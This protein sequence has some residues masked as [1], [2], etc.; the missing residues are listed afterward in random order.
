[1][2]D[3]IIVG[4][5]V[6][7]CASAYQLARRGQKVL[8]I[9]QFAL[10]HERG[11]SHGH[12]RIIRRS[13]ETPG[14]VR[15]MDAAY[16]AWR[17]LEADADQRLIVT[18]G[19]LDLGHPERSDVLSC[20]ESMRAE[21]VPFELMDAATVRQRFS[22]FVVSDSYVGVYQ[23]DAGILPASQCVAVLAQQAVSYGA[24][25]VAGQAV[26]R[27]APDGAGVIVSAGANTYRAQRAIITAGS[28]VS[29]LLTQ[30]D[31]DL[32]LEITREQVMFFRPQQP[33]AFA[34]GKFPIFIQYG[35]RSA[36]NSTPSFYGF[37]LFGEDGVKV[38]EHH[39]GRVIDPFTDDGAVDQ[40]A[41]KRAHAFLGD[42]I[43]LAAGELMLAQTCRYTNTPDTHFIVDRHPHYP[44]IVIGSPCSGHGFKFGA[45][46][47]SILADLAIQGETIHDINPFTLDRF[48]N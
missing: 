17:E 10:G 11:S 14:Y 21:G 12:S 46:M 20:C 45:L 6:M 22:Q 31:L 42:S 9:E 36:N 28:Y 18:T 44:Q 8:L 39:A 30:L 43:P 15:L 37:P 27:V 40:Q 41:I 29:P 47:G 4:A 2:Y 32:P 19:G 48:A 34:V 7:G 26:E 23:E 13:Y 25:I 5:G 1:M 3:V 24:E 35:E 38:A 16:G 33:A